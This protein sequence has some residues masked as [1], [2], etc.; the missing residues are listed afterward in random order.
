MV[1]SFRGYRK[2]VI[3][4][5]LRKQILLHELTGSQSILIA[6]LQVRM[7]EGAI[8]VIITYQLA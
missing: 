8:F 1:D 3:Y 4:S 5:L 6:G 7:R 2:I